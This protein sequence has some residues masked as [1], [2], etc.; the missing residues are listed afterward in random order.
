MIWDLLISDSFIFCCSLVCSNNGSFLALRVFELIGSLRIGLSIVALVMVGRG[1]LTLG[2]GI[3]LGTLG[4][5][6]SLL[7]TLL[8]DSI[9][10]GSL[11]I[12]SKVTHFD[13][14]GGT[15]CSVD[16]IL[17]SILSIFCNASHSTIPLLFLFCFRAFVKSFWGFTIV[18]S[19]IKVGCVMYLCLKCTVPDILLFLVFLT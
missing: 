8:G 1:E 16:G 2:G 15:C 17:F 5:G 6:C 13:F 3:L 18:S 4:A 19:S 11:A 7:N 9:S 14:M 12:L 10:L